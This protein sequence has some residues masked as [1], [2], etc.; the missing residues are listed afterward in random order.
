[1]AESKAQKAAREKR[2]A[3]ERAAAEQQEATA[4]ESTG[5]ASAEQGVTTEST[6]GDKTA[7]EG[8]EEA[9][10]SGTGTES[11]EAEDTSGDADVQSQRED[12]AEAKAK[13]LAEGEAK[14]EEEAALLA[15]APGGQRTALTDGGE[16]STTVSKTAAH[17]RPASGPLDA[18]Q[19]G[20]ENLDA[21]DDDPDNRVY[22]DE[23]G[24][25]DVHEDTEPTKARY[26]DAEGKALS[27]DDIF[28]AVEGKSFVV[29]KVRVYE[30]FTFPNTD[31]EGKRLAYVAGKRVSVG[32]AANVKQQISVNA[33]IL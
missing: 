29:T 30:V 5:D 28:E 16:G 31:T 3:E 25:R 2:E 1:M 20:V 17:A 9:S 18:P 7:P 19:A 26:V 15:A 32:E 6:E 24:P 11:P 22:G 27:A 8:S 33:Q 4:T 14:N 23:A 13:A 10:Q 21:S 12:E